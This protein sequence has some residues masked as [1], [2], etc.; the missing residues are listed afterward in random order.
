MEDT[1]NSGAVY[2]QENDEAF[3]SFVEIGLLAP[4]PLT[5]L[6]QAKTLFLDIILYICN[7]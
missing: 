1:F 6:D 4:M 3:G 2:H 5:T 7:Q